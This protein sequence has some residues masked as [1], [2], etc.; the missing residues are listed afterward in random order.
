MFLKFSILYKRI[1]FCVFSPQE[2]AWKSHVLL[3]L[4]CYWY[5]MSQ[6]HMFHKEKKKKKR[7]I[8]SSQILINIRG[9][10]MEKY[11]ELNSYGCA[12]ITLMQRKIHKTIA[13]SR[14]QSNIS[15]KFLYLLV[16]FSFSEKIHMIESPVA[17]AR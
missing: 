8:I 7:S 6:Y 17:I 1:L 2:V 3:N 12:Q 11:I 16:M 4:R 10:K 13:L 5:E 9:G 15:I 14:F